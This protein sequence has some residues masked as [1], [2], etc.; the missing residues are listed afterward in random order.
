MHPKTSLVYEFP[1]AEG[2]PYYPVPQPANA[3]L[4]KRYRALADATPGVQFVGR[5]ATYRYY[6]MDQVVAQALAVVERIEGKRRR[7]ETLETSA[8]GAVGRNGTHR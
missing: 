2:D 4:Y 6:N 1:R 5:L 8:N 3:E 7:V